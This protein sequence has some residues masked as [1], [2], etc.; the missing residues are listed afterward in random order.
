[1]KNL[2]NFLIVGASKSGTSSLY[3]YLQQHPDIFLSEKQKEGRYFS[4]M[5]GCFHGPGDDRVERTITHTLEDYKELFSSHNNE[6]AVGD[7]SPEYLY[8]HEQSIPLIKKDLGQDTRIIIILRSPIERAFSGY[9][10]F[11]RDKRETFSF[12]EGMKLEGERLKMNW[13]WAWQ[14]KNSGLY[15]EQVKAYLNGFKHVKVIVY[16]DFKYEGNKVLKEICR[17]LEVD[18]AFQFDTAYKYNVSGDPKNE[19]LFKLENSR[20]LINF[21]KKLVPKSMVKKLRNKMTGEKQMLKPEMDEVTRHELISF[22]R[23][24]VSKLQELIGQDLSHW[25]N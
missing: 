24:D 20:S 13:I 18:S 10:H 1:M 6:K 16:E 19:L 21:I 11:K 3:H 2:P 25:I 15:Y 22:F 4:Q 14:Y 17:F 9:F 23:E 7:I 8:F 12:A 5:S